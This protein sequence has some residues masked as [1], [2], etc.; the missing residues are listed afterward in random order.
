MYELRSP[1]QAY[2]LNPRITQP[3]SPPTIRAISIISK[4]DDCTEGVKRSY[5]VGR[6]PKQA[7]KERSHP[8]LTFISTHKYLSGFSLAIHFLFSPFRP[9]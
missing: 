6:S 1:H 5:P 7:N 3:L 8:I 2:S 4:G 9:R